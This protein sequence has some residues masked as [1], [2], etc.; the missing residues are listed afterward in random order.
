VLGS[1]DRRRIEDGRLV[2]RE[3]VNAP[4]SPPLEY[5]TE[6]HESDLIIDE[7]VVGA[8]SNGDIAESDIGEMEVESSGRRTSVASQV[9]LGCW[10]NSRNPS[11]TSKCIS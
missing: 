3:S 11:S 2:E 7:N 1:V 9:W 5:D 4:L 6:T 8:G 10:P